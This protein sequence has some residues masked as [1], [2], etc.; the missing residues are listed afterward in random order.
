MGRIN[1][2]N[3][4]KT[5]AISL[6][7]L[8][9]SLISNGQQNYKPKYN[10]IAHKYLIST[11]D[12]SKISLKKLDNLIDYSKQII[13]QKKY[14][15]KEAKDIISEIR[16]L[17]ER[18]IWIK[19]DSEGNFPPTP[20]NEYP[21]LEKMLFLGVAKENKLPIYATLIPKEHIEK[22]DSTEIARNYHDIGKLILRWD[23]NEEQDIFNKKNLSNKEDFDFN[24]KDNGYGISIVNESDRNIKEVEVI[25]KNNKIKTIPLSELNSSKPKDPFGINIINEE[26]IIKENPLLNKRILKQNIYL[27][28]LT[29]KQLIGIIGYENALIYYYQHGAHNPKLLEKIN[30]AQKNFPK[31]PQFYELKGDYF[32]RL[33]ENQKAKRYYKKAFKNNP[34]KIIK[35]KIKGCL[36]KN[37]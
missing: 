30:K 21:T 26:N 20:L 32:K 7:F 28:N 4:L 13:I 22:W 25:D 33:E 12:T 31:L 10:T 24:L 15:T 36:K 29:E 8:G 9:L 34:K 14:N 5:T 19:D 17:L 2:L 16:Y 23:P 6:G 1:L 11:G 35:N 18:N 37:Q 3:K 27:T